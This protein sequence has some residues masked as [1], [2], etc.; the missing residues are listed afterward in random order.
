MNVKRKQRTFVLTMLYIASLLGFAA[1]TSPQH[2]TSSGY[3]YYDFDTATV[4]QPAWDIGGYPLVSGQT[5][6]I[7]SDDNRC[8]TT[9]GSHY[10]G[11]LFGS[12]PNPTDAVWLVRSFPGSSSESASVAVS[13]EM[14]DEGGNN[15]VNCHPDW[16]R[17]YGGASQRKSMPT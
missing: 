11:V 5:S 3:Y 16:N 13:W 4:P 15:L 7:Y 8:P 6:Q 12:S 14:K 1:S 2:A 10:D 9:N 17:C